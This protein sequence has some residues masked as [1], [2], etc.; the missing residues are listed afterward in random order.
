MN[1]LR[2]PPESLT[3]VSMVGWFSAIEVLVEWDGLSLERQ[4]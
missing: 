2:V 1:L 3:G 4:I